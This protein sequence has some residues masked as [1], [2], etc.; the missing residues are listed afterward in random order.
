V[1]RAEQPRHALARGDGQRPGQG[2]EVLLVHGPQLQ[3][4][5]LMNQYGTTTIAA[6]QSL[7]SVWALH[8]RRG[9]WASNEMQV[10]DVPWRFAHHA[11]ASQRRHALQCWGAVRWVSKPN[12]GLASRGRG[13]FSYRDVDVG[14][15]AIRG[16]QTAV[17]QVGLGGGSP[18]RARSVRSRQW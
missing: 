11:R 10:C 1:S 17:T 18:F 15:V 9:V 2:I 5:A 16:S 6:R 12:G 7:S 4:T 14:A 3:G 13:G 8:V